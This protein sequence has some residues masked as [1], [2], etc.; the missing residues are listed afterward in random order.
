MN[1]YKHV[2]LS[3]SVELAMDL[4]GHNCKSP[5]ITCCC[6]DTLEKVHS[7]MFRWYAKK[8]AIKITRRNP[9]RISYDLPFFCRQ[10]KNALYLSILIS[11]F[12][13]SIKDMIV[14]WFRIEMGKCCNY[15]AWNESEGIR[16]RA[17]SKQQ[18]F[19]SVSA[20]LLTIRSIKR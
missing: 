10:L 18:M 14:M 4:N 9:I 5:H 1:A 6:T 12:A 8:G 20:D 2:V 11:T 15:M 13:E 3:I 16:K 7:S 19:F 17:K